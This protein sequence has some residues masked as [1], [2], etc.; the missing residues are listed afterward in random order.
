MEREKAPKFCLYLIHSE[1]YLFFFLRVTIRRLPTCLPSC[2]L[3]PPARLSL[4]KAITLASVRPRMLSSASALSLSQKKRRFI[5]PCSAINLKDLPM[6]QRTHPRG[7]TGGLSPTDTRSFDVVQSNRAMTAAISAEA[8]CLISMHVDPI[9]DLDR[10]QRD[11]VQLPVPLLLPPFPL[12]RHGGHRSID[13]SP[14]I[15]RRLPVL[16]RRFLVED[17][18]LVVPPVADPMKLAFELQRVRAFLRAPVQPRERREREQRSDGA[19]EFAEEFAA[20]QEW[21]HD[22]EA[23]G[24]D[25]DGG[26][27]GGPGFDSRIPCFGDVSVSISKRSNIKTN[28]EGLTSNVFCVGGGDD[29]DSNRGDN[30]GP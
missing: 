2:T 6:T 17:L 1:F 19:A 15:I 7:I 24:E 29:D 22:W 20:V 11:T 23:D 21:R 30:D 28:C 8:L 26:F 5:H 12:R 27:H 13:V 25:L 9:R 10:M 3:A 14:S 4:S 16:A 18:H